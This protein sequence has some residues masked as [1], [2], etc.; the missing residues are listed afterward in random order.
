M[1][2]AL[3]LLFVALHVVGRSHLGHGFGGHGDHG[4]QSGATEPGPQ[5][6]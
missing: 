5:Q 4:R 1:V 6:P 2:G 3:L